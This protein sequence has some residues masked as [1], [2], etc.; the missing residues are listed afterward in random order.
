MSLPATALKNTMWLAL[1]NII[2]GKGKTKR[3][4]YTHQ[5][6]TWW[7]QKLHLGL[8]WSETSPLLSTF[9]C[10]VKTHG[11]FVQ[12]AAFLASNESLYVEVL[13]GLDKSLSPWL[14]I[15]CVLFQT[16]LSC[17]LRDNQSSF[18]LH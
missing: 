12:L 4:S 6:S 5:K 17:F 11:F 8:F 1:K 14:E 7:L 10:L 13:S 16:V 3:N 9:L 15:F 18:I 2:Y